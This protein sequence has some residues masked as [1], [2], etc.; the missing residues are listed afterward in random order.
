MT[1]R[2]PNKGPPV[3]VCDERAVRAPDQRISAW[4]LHPEQAAARA[5]FWEDT[6]SGG[7]GN[8]A[9]CPLP[10]VGPQEIETMGTVQG[11]ANDDIIDG[12]YVDPVD[13]D[14]IDSGTGTGPGGGANDDIV[15]GLEGNDTI[16]AG[17]GNDVVF[18]GLD[19]DRL[20]GGV[21]NDWLKGNEGQ[22]ILFGG[23]DDDTLWGQEGDDTLKGEAGDDTLDGGD[24]IDALYGGD[25][26]D[27][28]RGDY[29]DYADGGAGG[30]DYDVL[31]LRG[32]GAYRL[33]DVRPDSNGNGIDGT[34][35][36]LDADGNP[37]GA[38]MLFVEIEQILDDGNLPPDAVDDT[39]SVDA[40]ETVVIPVLDNDTDPDG[41]PLTV[42]SASATNGTV[43]VN[44]D[45]TLSYT[46]DDGYTGPDTITYSISDGNGGTDTAEVAVTVNTGNLPPDAV[47]DTASVDAGETV[48]IPVLDNDTDPDGDP[49][50]V[51]SASATN[52][53]VTVNPDGTLS[54][55]PD[56]G[57]TGPDTI[58]YSITDGNGGTDTAEVAVT[59]NTGNLPPTP[60]TTPAASSTPARRSSFR[61]S[62]TTPIPTATRSGSSRPRPRTAPSSSMPTAPSATRRTTATR[63]RTRSPTRSPTTSRAP[64]PPS[65]RSSSATASSRA[66]TGPT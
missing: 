5:S 63:A 29:G 31:D 25:D 48:V 16:Y 52:G 18:G 15:E 7:D 47:D 59:V 66:P 62:R 41:D 32:L 60:W 38:T 14:Q 19:D 28:L 3:N 27:I 55:T 8:D 21:G 35:V 4:L 30:V 10:Q 6:R 58:T 61:S 22:D 36:F 2:G 17:D 26:R 1:V 44:P 23:D 40:G 43:T 9:V 13:G 12:T 34:V 20:Y 51:T 24:G 45:G 39:A 65:S 49:L 42:T 54:Y 11:T 64:T 37:T 33:E 50:T 56:D 57:Y 46:P 53:T